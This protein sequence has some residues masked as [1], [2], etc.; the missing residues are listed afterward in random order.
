[1]GVMQALSSAL[2]ASSLQPGFAG[3]QQIPAHVTQI[4]AQTYVAHHGAWRPWLAAGLSV[5]SGLG[6]FYNGQVAKA[7]VLACG[8]V[9]IGASITL[10]QSTVAMIIAP[11]WWVAGIVDAYRVALRG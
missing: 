5:I 3:T 7:M 4:P 9:A 11:M 6:Q 8:A 10:L 1:M 2:G